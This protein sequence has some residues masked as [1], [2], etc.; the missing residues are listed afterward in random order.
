VRILEEACS[1]PETLELV[2]EMRPSLDH[3]GDAGAPL[4]FL[5]LSTSIGVRYLHEIQYI[6]REMEDWFHVR[7]LS[8]NYN[9][10]LC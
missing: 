4:L 5:F 6:D 1:S 3:L 9:V 2:V 8:N 7:F 10:L